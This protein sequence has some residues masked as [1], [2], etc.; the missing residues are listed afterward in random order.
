M[1]GL[2][3]SP[4]LSSQDSHALH[5]ALTFLNPQQPTNAEIT[6]GIRFLG[7][8]IGSTAFIHNF[9]TQRLDKIL[10][11]LE[12]VLLLPHTQTQINHLLWADILTHPPQTASSPWWTSPITAHLDSIHES[13]LQ[14]LTQQHQPLPPHA[15]CIATLP[16]R[17]G[18]LGIPNS[19]AIALPSFIG[20]MAHSLR[21]AASENILSHYHSTIFQNWP[22]KPLP[23]FRALSTEFLFRPSDSNPGKITHLSGTKMS[24]TY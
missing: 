6:T 1:T 14:R 10:A 21:L 17:H 11:N 20:T 3:P 18:G 5:Q 7:H 9:T 22:S 24:P 4:N 13:F 8:P 19:R 23:L 15:L 2:S 16:E 12:R